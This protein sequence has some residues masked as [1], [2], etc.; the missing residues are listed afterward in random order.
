MSALSIINYVISKVNAACQCTQ[1]NSGTISPKPKRILKQCNT[2]S[3]K[4]LEH[5]QLKKQRFRHLQNKIKKMK[6]DLLKKY[7]KMHKQEQKV[8]KQK[9]EAQNIHIIIK[10]EG[11]GKREIHI[12][13][14]ERSTLEQVG[15]KCNLQYIQKNTKQH[16]V[17]DRKLRNLCDTLKDLEMQNGDILFYTYSKHP[18]LLNKY[19]EPQYAAKVLRNNHTEMQTT[20]MIKTTKTQTKPWSTNCEYT[21]SD[22]DS[23]SNNDFIPMVSPW[24]SVIK[25]PSI[26]RSQQ[27]KSKKKR[28]CKLHYS[29][30]CLFTFDDKLNRHYIINKHKI[31]KTLQHMRCAKYHFFKLKLITAIKVKQYK[32]K[33]HKFKRMQIFVQMFNNKTITLDVE[34]HDTIEN[35][36]SKIQSTEA[37]MF[38]MF[39]NYYM[40]VVFIY[41]N[42]YRFHLEYNV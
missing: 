29:M 32:Q 35:I 5:S 41:L 28:S 2:K 15:A 18:Y 14:H 16:W 23:D 17:F 26:Q 33:H 36:K 13:V 19:R 31:V 7:R 1:S 34:P 25:T 22:S 38:C 39:I 3:K 21:D 11:K 9:I 37:V 40:L 27:S 4:R 12:K 8:L 42:W 30:L 6:Q 10:I 20:S 24:P